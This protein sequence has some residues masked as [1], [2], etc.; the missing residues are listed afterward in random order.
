[1]LPKDL[2]SQQLLTEYDNND[3]DPH[4]GT[5][6]NKTKCAMVAVYD[7]AS[8]GGVI[9]TIPLND[10]LGNPAKLPPGAI[11]TNVVANVITQPTSLGA[12]TVGLGSN[13]SG[14]TADLMAQTAK[15][16]LPVG[17]VAGAPVGTAASWV[18]PIPASD[19]GLQVQATIAA[20]ALTAGKIYYNIEYV[21]NKLT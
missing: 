17:F 1:M 2:K 16:S 6:L 13:I 11:V 4:L 15:A 8:N 21:I 12:A 18:G 3:P 7:F 19:F 20:A 10:D 9:G 5:F 14:A